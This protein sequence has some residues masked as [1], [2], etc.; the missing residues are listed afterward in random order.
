MVGA[1]APGRDTQDWTAGSSPPLRSRPTS[2]TCSR[3][4]SSTGWLATSS[5]GWSA[6]AWPTRPPWWSPPITASASGRASRGEARH[7]GTGRTSPSCP[8]SSRARVRERGRSSTT[9]SRPS[10]SSDARR[11]ARHPHPMGCRRAHGSRRPER[12]AVVVQT[13][14]VDVPSSEVKVP[15]RSL[16]RGHEAL[17]RERARLFGSADW[18][19]CSG[20]PRTATCQD[21]LSPSS[22]SSLPPKRNDRR[23]VD[24]EAPRRDAAGFPLRPLTAGGIGDGSRRGSRAVPRRRGERPGRSHR[25]D[26]RRTWRRALLGARA[27]V[28]L[29]DR[30]EPRD[31]RL[32]RRARRPGPATDSVSSPVRERPA[33]QLPGCGVVLLEETHPSKGRA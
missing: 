17:V 7:L 6:R 25:A 21:A 10:T 20:L 26:V 19:A 12:P 9:T 13:R 4:A 28:G 16:V 33:N 22:R 23:R 14:Q 15:F 1:P 8:C 5:T 31:L 32:G 30:S 2:A 11:P 29:P 18:E 24:E 27:R 3:P